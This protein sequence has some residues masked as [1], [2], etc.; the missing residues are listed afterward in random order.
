MKAHQ[1]AIKDVLIL[2]PDIYEDHR[3]FFYESFNLKRFYDATG[4]DI[5]F[6]QDN[7][8]KSV[9]GV[10]RGLHFQTNPFAQSKLVRVVK[11]E[12]FDVAVDLRK[13]S[14]TFGKWIGEVISDQN[15]KQIWI[16]RGFAHGFLTLSNTAE[17][18]YKTDNYYSKENEEC[19]LW[20]DVDININWPNSSKPIIS[21]KDLNG[22]YLQNIR[23]YQVEELL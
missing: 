2:E 12:I 18:I 4:L 16:P 20:N 23:P 22:K 3:G 17:V 21:T 5:R 13:G 6:V 9:K 15:K 11:G 1:T 10:L 7:H 14:E 8:S 19:I